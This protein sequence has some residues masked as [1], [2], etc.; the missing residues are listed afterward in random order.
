MRISDRLRLVPAPRQPTSSPGSRTDP[1]LAELG[2]QY[3]ELST[4]VLGDCIALA[5]AEAVGHPARVLA[6]ARLDSVRARTLSAAGRVYGT[7]GTG[8]RFEPLL[9]PNQ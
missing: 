7:A 9:M 5:H 2:A 4:R 6:C 1:L 3:P 8:R